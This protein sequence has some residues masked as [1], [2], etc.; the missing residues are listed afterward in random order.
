MSFFLKDEAK[1]NIEMRK[2]CLYLE[3]V[4]KRAL[5]NYEDKRYWLDSIYSLPYGHPWIE[6]IVSGRVSINDVVRKIKG[7]DQYVYELNAEKFDHI[8]KDIEQKGTNALSQL[9][10]VEIIRQRCKINVPEQEL[11]IV[12]NNKNAMKLLDKFNEDT[13][14]EAF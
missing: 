1:T 14:E 2:F 12:K 5:I 6:E 11:A 10:D 9:S 7:N 13:C 3:Y 4:W 8:R